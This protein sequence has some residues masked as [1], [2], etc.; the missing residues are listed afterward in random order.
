[1]SVTPVSASPRT[2]A[3]VIG[4]APRYFGKSDACT[5]TQPSLGASSTSVG[6]MRPYATTSATS[7]LRSRSPLREFSGAQLRRL[8]HVE[9]ARDRSL[10]HRRC[11]EREPAP[12]RLVR[13]AHDP[14]D[15]GDLG[16][17][18]EARHRER[19]RAEEERAESYF[20]TS[21]LTMG[22]LTS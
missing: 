2:T 20:P 6:R 10:L 5:F 19:R 11:G 15:L 4:A 21:H 7:A 14:D 22:W 12:D 16:E 18:V 1:M 9:P 13:L 17:R 8:H 3:H